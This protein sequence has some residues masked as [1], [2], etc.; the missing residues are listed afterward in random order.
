MTLDQRPGV[1]RDETID[2]F[3][4]RLGDWLAA[5]APAAVADQGTGRRVRAS[6]RARAALYDEGF[7]GV[8]WP[9]DYGGRGLGPEYQAVVD[10]ELARYPDLVVGDLVTVGICAPTL[11]DV[12]SEEQKRRHLPAMLRGDES[13]TQLLSEPG[14]G[15]DLAGL[16]TRAERDGD[17]WIVNGQ[18]VW[19]SAADACD[20][21]IMMARTD[22][23]VPKHAGLSMFIVDLH[24]PGVT[25][26]PLRQITGA[27]EFNEVFL[28]DVALPAANLVGTENDGWRA[29]TRMLMHE[30]MAI[31]A[32]TGGSRMG[33]DMF[34]ALVDLA[35]RRG[36]AGDPVV[37]QTLVRVLEQEKIL[38]WIGQRMRAAAA[39]GRPPGAEGSVAK[40]ANSNLAKATTN[41]ALLLAGPA[42]VAWDPEVGGGGDLAA[43][44]LQ[45][46]MTAIAGGTSEIQRNTIGERVLGLPKEPQVDRDV[47]FRQVRQNPTRA[48]PG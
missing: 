6:R 20:F 39:A 34:G 1:A 48:V 14:A 37:R 12:G 17:V 43:A 25:I 19:T 7:V 35:R 5:N 38:G 2:D 21:A 18:K 22:P 27:A 42:S 47:P 41:V 24:A 46:P 26:R 45:A 30:R 32:G 31:G 8:T 11:L 4:R 10:A 16:Q 40:L 13:W 28:D 44:F 36:R 33:R 3:G 9:A 15:S 23:D 29:L